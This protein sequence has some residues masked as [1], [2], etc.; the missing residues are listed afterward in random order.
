MLFDP[1]E[2]TTPVNWIPSWDPNLTTDLIRLFGAF[3]W[4]EVFVPDPSSEDPL[5]G[6]TVV[7]RPLNDLWR[8]DRMIG[9]THFLFPL[10]IGNHV[11]HPRYRIFYCNYV[12]AIINLGS[13]YENDTY[14]IVLFPEVFRNILTEHVGVVATAKNL[15][16]DMETC[17]Y[18]Y[19][20]G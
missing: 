5:Q 7:H 13:T 10:I 2:P 9:A 8:I 6:R 18:G 4:Y 1:G 16:P 12:V 3:G 14:D 20:F 11:Y 15:P 17:V 19:L